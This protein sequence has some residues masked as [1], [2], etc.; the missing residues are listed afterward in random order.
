MLKG[1]MVT[2]ALNRM[3]VTLLMVA[4]LF[5][6]F[7]QVVF[8][9]EVQ[10]NASEASIGVAETA[11]GLRAVFPMSADQQKKYDQLMAGKRVGLKVGESRII[12]EDEDG[13]ISIT[14]V[15]S[16]TVSSRGS[17]KTS[18]QSYKITKNIL[19]QEMQL[20][21]VSLEC[22][23]YADG[24]NGYISNL[25][26]TY[27]DVN[28]AW[29]CWW[30]DYKVALPY[31]HA[32]WLNIASLGSSYSVMFAADYNPYNNTLSFGIL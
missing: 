2:K 16:K 9:E 13:V 25:R 5:I 20:V 10:G 3:G 6:S 19:E 12:G 28:E 14:C 31:N 23:W 7:P 27:R 15:D 32:L 24:I 11:S 8:A 22:T 4:T 17:T 30:D 21:R 29:I 1:R 26:G 18:Y